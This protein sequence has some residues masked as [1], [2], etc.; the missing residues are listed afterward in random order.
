MLEASTADRDRPPACLFDD[1][2]WTRTLANYYGL[3]L[4]SVKMPRGHSLPYTLLGEGSQ[5][6]VV[7]FPFSDY[8]P[9]EDVEE[10]ESVAASLRE[11][12][13]QAEVLLKT[14]L[15]HDVQV[16]GAEVVRRAV[17]HVIHADRGGPSAKFKAN[18]RRAQRDGVTARRA[19]DPGAVGRFYSLYAALRIAKFGSLPQPLGFFRAV[20]DAFAADGSSFFLE[21]VYEGSVIASFLIVVKGSRAFYKFGASSLDALVPKPNNLLFVELHGGLAEGHYDAID[22]GL[23]GTGESYAGL[24]YFKRSAGGEESPI[25]YLRWRPEGFDPEPQAMLRAALGKVVDEIVE[26]DLTPEQLDR[27]SRAIYPHFA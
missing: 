22:L 17:L 7:A 11:R 10:V 25:T 16:A 6:R 4:R 15:P 20:F 1:P 24:R 2:R 13:P 18:S 3:D 8:L 21:A 19:N 23:S 5:A 9:L 26:A 14:C 27:L 12:H